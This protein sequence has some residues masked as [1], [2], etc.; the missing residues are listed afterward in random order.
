MERTACFLNIAVRRVLSRP[1]LVIATYTGSLPFL[2][3]V[4]KGKEDFNVKNRGFCDRCGAGD[5]PDTDAVQKRVAGRRWRRLLCVPGRSAELLLWPERA[6]GQRP[7][8][9][10]NN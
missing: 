2:W 1:L 4:E 8:G 9:L 3:V 7:V 6:S 5:A 10:F